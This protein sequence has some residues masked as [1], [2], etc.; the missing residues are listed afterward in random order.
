MKFDFT[1]LG[2]IDHAELELGPL[3]LICG[4][5]NTGKTYVTYAIYGLLRSW[6]NL[7]VMAIGDEIDSVAAR[8]GTYKVDLQEMFSGQVNPYLDKL[9]AKYTEYLPKVFG[10]GDS[11]FAKARVGI[12]IDAE[13][14]ILPLS[15]QRS[16][17]KGPAGQVLATVVKETGSPVLETLVADDTWV[18]SPF[19]GLSDFVVDA[20]GDIVF[21]HYL[22]DTF[23]ASAERTGAAIFRKEL[24]FARTRMI[25]A[26]GTLDTKE[27]RNPVRLLQSMEVDYAWPVQDNVDFVRQLETIDKQTGPLAKAHPELVAAF[28][29]IIGG[30]Y[31]VIKDK[32][33]VFQPKGAGKPRL[34]M[35]ESSSSVRALLDIGFYLRCQAKSGDLFMIDE[36][37]LNLHPTNQ[38]ALARL[39]ARMVNHGVRVFIT[40][41]SDYLVKEINSLIMLAQRTPWTRRVQEQHGYIEE[42][43]LSPDQVRLYM[44]CT[45]TDGRN[46]KSKRARIN[47]LRQATI[48]P[49]QGIEVTTFD[50]TIEEMNNIQGE[51][52]YGADD[53]FSAGDTA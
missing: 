10:A 38:R 42:E 47:T 28:E 27:L 1:N 40:T 36:P 45:A 37:E 15:F 4:E 20:I 9:T 41:H 25:E 31:K 26:L 43:L 5:N 12:H 21:S 32:G 34:S 35:T 18:R 19:S 23:I 13:R 30:S 7:L 22:P 14:D 2:L 46:G 44:T 51:I 16:I 49:D 53:A 39:L 52:L 11:L 17:K 8:K 50:T 48:Y 29:A 24:D 33:L 6:R 3:T